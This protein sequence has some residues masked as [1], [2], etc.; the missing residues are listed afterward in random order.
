MA[1]ILYCQQD[2]YLPNDLQFIWQSPNAPFQL[3]CQVACILHCLQDFSSKWSTMYLTISKCP[4]WST[5]WSG[6]QLQCEVVFVH[7]SWQ[8]FY[9]LNDPICIWQSQNNPIVLQ[10]KEEC[11]LVLCY[12]FY[13]LQMSQFS[14][15]MKWHPSEII[16]LFLIFYCSKYSCNRK[17]VLLRPA[18]EDSTLLELRFKE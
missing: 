15:I 2:F 18:T 5:M 3:Q 4:S 8:D 1:S 12:V 10:Y 13:N 7:H 14:C 6:V 11:I 17:C 16:Y 9:F